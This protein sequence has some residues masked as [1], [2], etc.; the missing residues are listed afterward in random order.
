MSKAEA[1]HR[2]SSEA[3]G[4][5]GTRIKKGG[6]FGGGRAGGRQVLSAPGGLAE[7][8]EPPRGPE[9]EGT[10]PCSPQGLLLCHLQVMS[11]PKG[12]GEQNLKSKKAS[13]CSR[14]IPGRLSTQAEPALLGHPGL[15]QRAGQRGASVHGAIPDA[16]AQHHAQDHLED[17]RGGARAA[18]STRLPGWGRRPPAHSP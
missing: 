8:A 18:V 7:L 10:L 13:K 9:A 16:A 15:G 14:V 17:L 11:A 3:G 4:R 6:A 2:P 1:A 12:N 5:K